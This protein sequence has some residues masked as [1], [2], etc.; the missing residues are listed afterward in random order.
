M[1]LP[2]FK[3]TVTSTVPVPY[4]GTG[5]ER[6]SRS[7][8]G[9]QIV[10]DYAALHYGNAAD[11]GVTSIVVSDIISDLLTFV[12]RVGLDPAEVFERAARSF[13]GDFEDDDR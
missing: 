4:E 13:E 8:R 1:Q 5:M 11:R 2:T 3:A 6:I 9:N 12:L 7:L 10:T